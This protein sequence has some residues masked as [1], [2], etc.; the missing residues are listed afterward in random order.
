MRVSR[1]ILGRLR[2]MGWA[3]PEWLDEKVLQRILLAFGCSSV[4]AV[5]AGIYILFMGR[6]EVIR[7]YMHLFLLIQERAVHR[8]VF[9][10]V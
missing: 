3:V 10:L 4:L 8:Q 1:W 9:H 2:K 6:E 5:A 7:I